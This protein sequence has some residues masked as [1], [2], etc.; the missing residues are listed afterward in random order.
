MTFTQ[1]FKG[2]LNKNKAI[3]NPERKQRIETEQK[4]DREKAERIRE[5]MSGP[6]F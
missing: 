3:E 4:E 6:K 1:E 2:N 5:I